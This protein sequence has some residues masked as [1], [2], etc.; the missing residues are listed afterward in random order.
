[1]EELLP[2]NFLQYLFKEG[3]VLSLLHQRTEILFVQLLFGFTEKTKNHFTTIFQI[4]EI[5][6]VE[7]LIEVLSQC[8]YVAEYIIWDWGSEHGCF[9]PFVPSRNLLTTIG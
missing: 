6:P 9:S 7:E 4:V 2:H 5:R 1:M 3:D 8:I